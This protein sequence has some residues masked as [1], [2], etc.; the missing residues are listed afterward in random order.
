M[1]KQHGYIVDILLDGHVVVLQRN[2][3]NNIAPRGDT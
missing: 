1:Y 3:S 2:I